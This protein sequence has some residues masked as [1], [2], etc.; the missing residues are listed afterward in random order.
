MSRTPISIP[1]ELLDRVV[2]IGTSCAGKTTTAARLARA[3]SAPHIELDALHWGPEWR[4]VPDVVFREKVARAVSASRWVCDG[5]YGAVRDLIWS[6]ATAVVWLDYRFSVVFARALR[7]TI[8]RVVTRERIYSGNRESFAR[9][10]LSR[11][12]ILLW[13]ISTHGRRRRQYEELLGGREYAHLHVLRLGNP[14]ETER[15]LRA[16]EG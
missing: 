16:I 14:G 9:A 8:G 7:R 11:D 15:H 1:T 4:E 10:F 3:L 6:R 5:N 13:V 2:V 12:S